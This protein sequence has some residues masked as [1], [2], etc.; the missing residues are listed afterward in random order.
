MAFL[1]TADGVDIIRNRWPGQV[2][3]RVWPPNA[4]PAPW[5]RC[6]SSP[7]ELSNWCSV[8]LQTRG[9]AAVHVLVY[10]VDVFAGHRNGN[11]HE[12]V[13]RLNGF[14]GDL[15]LGPHVLDKTRNA[16][17]A[18][19]GEPY[20]QLVGGRFSDVFNEQTECLARV[21]R[22]VESYLRNSSSEITQNVIDS[23]GAVRVM[24]ER[25]TGSRVGS[26]PVFRR[27]YIGRSWKLPQEELRP[28]DFVEVAA[29]VVV[30]DTAT[31]NE[32]QKEVKMAIVRV[33][34]LCKEEFVSLVMGK[35][36]EV[37]V[38]GKLSVAITIAMRKVGWIRERLGG[39][40]KTAS[41]KAHVQYY[42]DTPESEVSGP[43]QVRGI[44]GKS[45][46]AGSHNAQA[47][48][49]ADERQHSEETDVV[50]TINEL[51]G[52]GGAFRKLVRK[53]RLAA[54]RRGPGLQHLTLSRGHNRSVE[55]DCPFESDSNN[56]ADVHT[57]SDGYSRAR[58]AISQL[59]SDQETSEEFKGHVR[60]GDVDSYLSQED[61]DWMTGKI[62]TPYEY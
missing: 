20:I 39:K 1:S 17:T 33:T 51:E 27:D 16:S 2:A 43:P 50:H 31:V 8:E 37:A 59:T 58:S 15:H 46:K 36:E 48:Q 32:G 40:S 14:L 56:A 62:G 28:G 47:E 22:L 19:H 29:V 55:A 53:D 30:N 34:R 5:Q 38:A 41:D 3:K 10:D 12:V 35:G 6:P 26:L 7:T 61:L 54:I 60:P 13:F 45:T 18:E 42:V 49:L 25:G 44:V 23:S 9:R 11:G 4:E 52:P 21:V 24:I 57:E